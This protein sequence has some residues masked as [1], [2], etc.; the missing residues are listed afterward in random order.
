[1]P[2]IVRCV[3]HPEIFGGEQHLKRLD[4]VVNLAAYRLLAEALPHLVWFARADGAVTFYNGRR[5]RY[6]GLE[7]EPSGIYEWA[8]IVHPDDLAE[9]LNAWHRAVQ[10][11]TEYECEHRVRMADGSFRWHLSRALPLDTGSSLMWFGTAT[12]T[13]VLADARASLAESD[14]RLQTVFAGIDQGFCI[15][16]LVLDADGCPVDYRFLETNP[17]FED[18][19]GLHDAAGRTALELVPGLERHWV[20]AYASVALGGTP[21]RFQQES[22][23]MGRYFDVFAMPLAPRGR[24]A[25]VFADITERHAALEALQESERRFRNMADNAPVM[26]WV[27]DAE[28][29]CTYLN[30]MWYEFTGQTEAEGLGRGWLDAI[31]PG[32]TVQAAATFAEATERRTAFTL[33]YRLRGRDGVYRWAVD[34]AAPRFSGQGTFLGFIGSVLD[35]TERKEAERAI[36]AQRDHEHEIAF[37]LQLSMLPRAAVE[38]ARIEIATAYVTGSDALQV[39]GDWYE[40]FHAPDGRVVV[41]VGDVVGHNAE[42]AAAMGQLRA[43]L[44]AMTPFVDGPD[45]LLCELDDFARRHQITDFATALCIF[46]DPNNGAIEY[47][48]AGHP[49]A[50]VCPPRGA[51]R[52]L[53]EARSIPLGIEGCAGRP[54]ATASIE[55]GAVLIAYSDGL[56]ERRGESIDLGLHR[57]RDTVERHRDESVHALCSN[58]LESLTGPDDLEDDTVLVVLRRT[59]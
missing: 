44:L 35:I 32:D 41:V 59:L 47:S 1:M 45:Q 50:L 58:T 36:A 57:L 15:C 28:G 3:G 8:P 56:I 6:G 49:P 7:P 52:W 5:A 29:E 39:G 48:C 34:A 25:L 40:T 9:T 22:K 43:G 2:T 46:L 27:T 19:T 24:F 51:V 33:D 4:A 17:Q 53:D 18:A 26:I 54:T 38:D 30:R 20:E 37:R 21:V 31:H 55:P 12:D 14:A 10:Q 11:G 23:V 16:E 13:Q 42:A